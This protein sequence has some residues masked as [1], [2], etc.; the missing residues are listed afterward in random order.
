MIMSVLAIGIVAM[1][2]L[3][4]VLVI[5]LIVRRGWAVAA[6]LVT[7]GL[8]V[9]FV[10][11]MAVT[12]LFVAQYRTKTV[13]RDVDRQL[14]P[15][16]VDHTGL[17]EAQRVLVDPINHPAG[18]DELPPPSEPATDKKDTKI[19]STETA[20]GTETAESEQPPPDDDRPDWVGTKPFKDGGVY[21]VPVTV[22]PWPTS[23]ESMKLLPAAVDEEIA[24]Y[25]VRRLGRNA[26]AKLKLPRD[27]VMSHMIQKD[28]W[29]EPLKID[30]F[31]DVKHMVGRDVWEN[32][33]NA[34]DGEWTQLHALVKFD[35]DVNQR[36]DD[37][38]ANLLRIERLQ[39]AGV[40]GAIAMI[41][42][43]AVYSYLKIDLKTS[44][45]YRGRLRAGA[46][47]VILAVIVAVLL[48][49]A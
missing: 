1:L 8:L 34:A 43:A 39:A 28:V 11:F 7:V 5:A 36:L 21:K 29:E 10:P 38:W 23:E 12:S 47:A 45:A 13:H 19:A 22:G 25:A 40:L 31:D 46:L 30:S 32:T 37:G 42:L 24:K 15:T 4:I 27:Y 41:I 48:N 2:V 49:H 3:V 35:R 44:G 18:P 17:L 14:I 9:L 16:E 33:P 20:K 26:A 6:I